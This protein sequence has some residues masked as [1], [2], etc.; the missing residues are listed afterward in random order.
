MNIRDKQIK[1]ISV[2]ADL[3]NA[4]YFKVGGVSTKG[5]TISRIAF[6]DVESYMYDSVFYNIFHKGSDGVEELWQ[7]INNFQNVL[8][9]YV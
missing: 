3:K 8:V 6:A 1:K 7:T 2:G 9:E 4:I 5:F